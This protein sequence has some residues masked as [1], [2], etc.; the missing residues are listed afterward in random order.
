MTESLDVSLAAMP[1]NVSVVWMP[2][3]LAVTRLSAA[4]AGDSRTPVQPCPRRSLLN[5]IFE[6]ELRD[7]NP[8]APQPVCQR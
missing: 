8:R 2:L 1:I 4:G 7:A 3:V 5:W 6:L